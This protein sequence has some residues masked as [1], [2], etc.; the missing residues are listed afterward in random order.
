MKPVGLLP[1]P[2]EP[3]TGKYPE[4]DEST[5]QP[6][7]LWPAFKIHIDIILGEPG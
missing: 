2:Q 4:P 1:S 6:H 3:A 7:T 5:P